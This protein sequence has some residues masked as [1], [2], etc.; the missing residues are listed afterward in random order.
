[1]RKRT[2]AVIR[3]VTLEDRGLLRLHGELME[4][5]FPGLHTVSVCSRTSPGAYAVRRQRPPAVPKIL[6][7]A[8]KLR[9]VDALVVSCCGDPAVEELRL[10]LDIPVI[11][12]GAAVCAVA[13]VLGRHP[14]VL[15]I[16]EEVPKPYQRMLGESLIHLGRPE[17]ITC[18]LDLMTGAGREAVIRKAL[19]LKAHGADCLALAC[20]G[21]STIRI[22]E[23]LRRACGIPGGGPGDGRGA[24]CLLRHREKCV[25]TERNRR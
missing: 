22:A 8:R 6:E 18:T 1:M 16:M 17:H 10:E 9:G 5:A 12:A 24:V 14:G 7:I 19:E 21:M 23:D 15:G 2:A 11:G 20:T 4:A 13:G 3:V 25:I